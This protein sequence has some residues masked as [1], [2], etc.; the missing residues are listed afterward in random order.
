MRNR[1]AAPPVRTAA[2]APRSG[3]EPLQLFESAVLNGGMVTQVDP[4]DLQPNQ[5]SLAVN[6]T[7]RYDVVGRRYG[8]TAIAPTKPNS[9]K[10][11]QF[12]SYKN[13]SGNVTLY[14]FDK[15]SVFARSGGSWTPITGAALSGTDNNAITFL[16]INN[17]AFFSNQVNVLQE[18]NVGANT[19]A[20]AGN[21]RAY[22]Y[23]CSFANRIVGA[24]LVSGS[25]SPIEVG[26]CGD[27]NFTEWNPLVD[28]SAG[29]TPLIDNPKEFSDDI[30]GIFGFANQMLVMRERSIWLASKQPSAT[31]PFYFETA[32]PEVGSDSPNSITQIPS[33]VAWYDRRL[34]NVF[35]YTIG[36]PAP[37]P[38]GDAVRKTIG[39]QVVDKTKLFSGWDSVNSEY[40]LGIPIDSSTI[41]RLWRYN[42][43]TQ[44]WIYDEIGYISRVFALDFSEATGSIDELIGT[45]DSL[46][47]FIDDLSPS[48]NVPAL[49]YGTTTGDILQLN[50][51]VTSDNL[52]EPTAEIR[53]KLFKL[54]PNDIN[55][56]QLHIEYIPQLGGSFTLQYSKD[57]GTTWSTYKAVS[58]T[59]NDRGKRLTIVC[60]KNIR[61]RTFMWRITGTSGTYDIVEYAV[62][63]F[64]VAGYTRSKTS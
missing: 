30:T 50:N 48:V 64:P 32:V 61:S 17:R 15:N 29:S 53:S 4:V 12:V 26:W 62:Y 3:G 40:I 21:S 11:L 5:L 44:A 52:V 56:A 41:V 39:T 54:N 45:I 22:K 27:V 9:N 63:V 42:F 55:I 28:P 14:R 13:F 59:I 1:F 19:Y 60:N 25:P 18:I 57:G 38:I 6:V 49:F 47:G 35:A 33:G 37:V 36:S 7:C 46:V 23:Y 10:L 51:A 43:Q 24:N 16:G 20:A 2:K 8:S 34:N 31:D 58:F